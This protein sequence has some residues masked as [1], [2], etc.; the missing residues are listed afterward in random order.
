MQLEAEKETSR[1]KNLLSWLG[2]GKIRSPRAV[3][4]GAAL[5]MHDS[6]GVSLRKKES[7]NGGRRRGLGGRSRVA[8]RKN[9]PAPI[10][11]GTEDLV[12]ATGCNP[13]GFSDKILQVRRKQKKKRETGTAWAGRWRFRER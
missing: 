13:L 5:K 11:K 12:G 10:L 9:G 7:V 6:R 8:S 2:E 1:Q 3:Q 4:K